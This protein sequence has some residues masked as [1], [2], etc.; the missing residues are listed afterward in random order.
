M[1]FHLLCKVRDNERTFTALFLKRLHLVPQTSAQYPISNLFL[2]MWHKEFHCLYLEVCL[3][4]FA[5]DTVQCNKFTPRCRPVLLIYCLSA[6]HNFAFLLHFGP[7]P[8]K[9]DCL[10]AL[11][12]PITA[13]APSNPNLSKKIN[14]KNTKRMFSKQLLL[15]PYVE[16]VQIKLQGLYIF[17]KRGCMVDR[18]AIKSGIM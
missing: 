9:N 4:L 18:N 14:T 7:P 17:V 15:K 3:V 16:L 2:P 1:C 10:L 6:A 12:I 5:R 8:S 11:W 13:S